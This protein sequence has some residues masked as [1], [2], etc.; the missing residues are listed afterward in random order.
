V[1]ERGQALVVCNVAGPRQ[2]PA[3]CGGRPFPVG[4]LALAPQGRGSQVVRHG[5]ARGYNKVGGDAEEAE[6]LVCK[7]SLS[8]FE[9]RRYLQ[10]SSTSH[11][12]NRRWGGALRRAGE[13]GD[14]QGGRLQILTRPP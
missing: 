11:D 14:E 8:G 7:T 4:H 10:F 6:A 3:T 5:S 2:G 12:G 13:S 9:S 1:P